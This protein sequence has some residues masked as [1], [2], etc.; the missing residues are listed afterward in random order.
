MDIRLIDICLPDY[1]QGSNVPYVQIVV[2]RG[3]SRK[4]V[5]GAIRRGV[6]SKDFEVEGWGEDQ[7][8]DL[9]RMINA[10]LLKYLH[11]YSRGMPSNEERGTIE[12]VYAYVAVI[13]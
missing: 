8:D 2:E 4:E 10:K 9:R 6:E 3:M 11:T 13:E 12:P 5:D 1:F 7:Y